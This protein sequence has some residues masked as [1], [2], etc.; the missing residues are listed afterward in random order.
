MKDIMSGIA[1]TYAPV[2]RREET[3]LIRLA[4]KG[5]RAKDRLRK[6]NSQGKR[7]IP[8]TRKERHALGKEAEDGKNATH[9]LLEANYPFIIYLVKRYQ[10]IAGTRCFTKEDAFQQGCMALLKAIRGIRTGKQYAGLRAYGG[11]AIWHALKRLAA[12]HRTVID[13]ATKYAESPHYNGPYRREADAAIHA[14]YLSSIEGECFTLPIPR[15]EHDAG[16]NIQWAVE[17]TREAFGSRSAAILQMRLDGLTWQQ[18]GNAFGLTRE[19]VRQVS[20][21]TYTF[22]A[23]LLGERRPPKKPRK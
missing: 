9:R 20:E 4:R 16:V 6:S 3:R 7:K 18:I 22:L 17:K 2:D 23:T 15:A 8:I 14:A 10:K 11:K 19:R 1:R 5:E 12:K 21:D 13:V